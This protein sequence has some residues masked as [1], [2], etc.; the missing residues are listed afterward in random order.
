[1]SYSISRTFLKRIFEV[2][3]LSVILASTYL[4][5][6]P[7]DAFAAINP[8]D[9]TSVTISKGYYAGD[10]PSGE[11][12]PVA[13]NV[14]GECANSQN[15]NNCGLAR[16]EGGDSWTKYSLKSC[17]VKSYNEDTGALRCEAQYTR[18]EK[19]YSIGD[20]CT[21]GGPYLE[22]GY[23]ESPTGGPIY[24]TC[25]SYG[26]PSYVAPSS[27]VAFDS[28]GAGDPEGRCPAG[29]T[30]EVFCSGSGC[31][32]AACGPVAAPPPPPTTLPP[33]PQPGPPPPPSCDPDWTVTCCSGTDSLSCPNQS[34]FQSLGYTYW[35]NEACSN[36]GGTTCA[37]PDD[38]GPPPDDPGPPPP[39]PAPECDPDQ[40]T[41]AVSVN[42]VATGSNI[43]FYTSGTQGST[44][45]ND[46]WTPNT[47]GR[48][49]CVGG[50]WGSKTCQA[51]AAGGVTW[52]HE[53]RNC[54]PNGDCNITSDICRK[55][56]NFSAV[57]ID[58]EKPICQNLTLSK[59]SGFVGDSVTISVQSSD[60]VEVASIDVQRDGSTIFTHT[61]STH[62]RPQFNISPTWTPTTAGTFRI[63]ANVRDT[64][65]NT[66]DLTTSCVKN[67]EA[68]PVA[69]IPASCDPGSGQFFGCKT[70]TATNDCTDYGSTV[71]PNYTP[72][73]YGECQRTCDNFST[74]EQRTTAFCNVA[75]GTIT[76]PASFTKNGASWEPGITIST[77][78]SATNTGTD[79]AIFN[80][81]CVPAGCDYRA[82]GWTF[83]PACTTTSDV[84]RSCSYTLPASQ[85]PGTRTFALF[86]KA[87][88]Q[89]FAT[90]N[91]NYDGVC[92]DGAERPIS[93]TGV[94]TP[95]NVCTL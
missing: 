51:T 77:T 56:L 54:S 6:N 64:S 49:N 65:G 21:S 80:G 58:R 72:E 16:C 62:S 1:M 31:G 28:D 47:T 42:P 15:S 37:P 43:T 17:K 61:N 73:R 48:V 13:C 94:Q 40:L 5:L 20:K 35:A 14:T 95:G 91:T 76:T 87:R 55:T 38:P 11:D 92:T 69:W 45:I 70:Q 66:S 8:N 25:C 60:N 34:P 81:N 4:V 9:V 82:S 86:N 52:T 59:S 53:W 85:Q 29:Y 7:K 30:R 90:S 93:C 24:K 67:Y 89:I 41:M 74:Q 44:H 2:F 75:R 19:V 12:C 83:I 18:D 50:F 36:K 10:A 33:P 46:T 26:S 27:C 84:S 88:N 3:V 39:P 68:Q 57:D 32:Q 71:Y 79:V 23:C 78:S 22:P 63:T